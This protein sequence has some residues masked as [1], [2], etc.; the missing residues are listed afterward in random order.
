MK[1]KG[2]HIT[3]ISNAEKSFYLYPTNTVANFTTQLYQPF[4][5]EGDWEIALTEIIFPISFYSVEKDKFGIM[6]QN[7]EQ[8]VPNLVITETADGKQFLDGNSIN[9]LPH[10]NYKTIQQ[11]INAIH[12]IP[13]VA[14]A[15]FKLIH[16]E[17]TGYVEAINKGSCTVTFTKDLA[18]ALGFTPFAKYTNGYGTNPAN[19]HINIP[20]QVFVYCD[21]A[22]PQFVG[23]GASKLLRNVGIPDVTKFGEIYTKTYSNPHYIPILKKNFSSIEVQLKSSTDEFVPFQFGPSSVKVHIRPAL[24]A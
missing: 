3:L 24:S 11:L 14:E 17:L 16:H 1:G 23:D 13:E 6:I 19:L 8:I 22:E 7:K 4:S 18:R 9:F 15:K 20:Q 5:L 10:G 2:S 21:I 12:S